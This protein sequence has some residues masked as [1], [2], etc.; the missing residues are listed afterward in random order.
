MCNHQFATMLQFDYSDSMPKI[1][2]RQQSI[3]Q[4]FWFK[5]KYVT[6]NQAWTCGLMILF[7]NFW[8]FTIMVFD[9]TQC[10][11]DGGPG[12]GYF[13]DSQWCFWS[14]DTPE[15]PG[16][17][18]LVFRKIKEH[19]WYLKQIEAIILASVCAKA[20]YGHNQS[21]KKWGV[22]D[23]CHHSIKVHT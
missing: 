11:M 16:S 13:L 4:I 15:P 23:K 7:P 2:T 10:W 5:C 14:F 18:S 3:S 12:D 22:R 20:Q 21:E 19:N 8:C 6:R 1:K 9:F 17:A